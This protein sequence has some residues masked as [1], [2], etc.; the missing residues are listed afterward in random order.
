M[1][2]RQVSVGFNL[3]AVLKSSMLAATAFLLVAACHAD[4]STPVGE[5]SKVIDRFVSAMIAGDVAAMQRG[6]T[7]PMVYGEDDYTDV[8]D[9]QAGQTI[10]KLGPIKIHRITTAADQ[11]AVFAE[12]GA[13][14]ELL[15]EKQEL[16]GRER[17]AFVERMQDRMKLPRAYYIRVFRSEPGDIG[18]YLGFGVAPGAHRVDVLYRN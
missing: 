1:S 14:A 11:A 15:V 8:Y 17:D 12:L 2:R 6:A 13:A 5:A 3:K 10:Y 16:E 9:E 18:H 4:G 7:L